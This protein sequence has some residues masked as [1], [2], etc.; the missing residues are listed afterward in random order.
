MPGLRFSTCSPHRS[1]KSWQFSTQNANRT[2]KVT[3]RMPKIVTMTE[4]DDQRDLVHQIVEAL[5]QNGLV[6]VPTA[7]SYLLVAG[8]LNE[9]ATSRLGQVLGTET[10]PCSLV[11]KSVEEA[12]DYVPRMSALARRMAKRFW[13]GPVIAEFEAKPHDGLAKSL[14]D[15]AQELIVAAARLSLRIPEQGLLSNVLQLISA[16]LVA[17]PELIG[18]KSLR[19]LADVEELCGDRVDFV[20]DAGA[21]EFNLPATRIQLSGDQWDILRPG[22]VTE[23]RLL[24]YASQLFV[25][26]CTGNTCRSPMAEALF[27]SLMSKRLGCSEVE[28]INHGFTAISAGLSAA[29]ASPASPESVELMAKRGLDLSC[30]ASQQLTMPLLS[31]CDAVYTM[32]RYHREV[33]V[34]SCP[35]LAELVCTLSP[36]GR[37]VMD[38]IGMGFSAYE[39]CEKEIEGYI[40]SLIDSLSLG[41]RN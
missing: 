41:E 9:Q 19:S 11:L 30:H 34:K 29:Y 27:R 22:V 18:G 4:V 33:I 3:D 14:S 12:I 17:S 7:T 15:Q 37:D 20:V 21:P 6:A 24:Q 32:T 10:E 2:E 26:V 25:F 1:F 31:Q 38:P 8:S 5:S 13:P 23:D 39:A 40:Q 28:L 16:P 35:E 36:D